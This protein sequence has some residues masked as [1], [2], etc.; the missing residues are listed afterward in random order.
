MS[1]Q[2]LTYIFVGLSFALYIGIAVWS[3]A[4]S[5]KDFYVA[6][7]GVHPLAR[8][9]APAPQQRRPSATLA[10]TASVAHAAVAQLGQGAAEGGA[11]GAPAAPPPDLIVE[12]RPS[13]EDAASVRQAMLRA[14]TGKEHE[15]WAEHMH[16]QPAPE[17]APP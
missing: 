12:Q 13:T 16:H 15:E 5:T 2:L 3:R 17:V 7:G 4:S 11:A 14:M 6:G 10:S 8:P 9:F 1:T